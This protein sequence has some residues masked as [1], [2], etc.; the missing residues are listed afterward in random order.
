MEN[1][2]FD[3]SSYQTNVK[4]PEN[5]AKKD[6]SFD[7]TKLKKDIDGDKEMP[8][9]EE[10]VETIEEVTADPVEETKE[11]VDTTEEQNVE[12]E[13][14]TPEEKIEEPTTEVVTPIEE[15]V[16]AK[17]EPEAEVKEEHKK[18]RRKRRTKKEIEAEKSVEKVVAS[19]EPEDDNPPKVVYQEAHENHIKDYNACINTMFN[20]TTEEEWERLK[21]TMLSDLDKIQIVDDINPAT[22]TAMASDINRVFD[23]VSYYYYTYKSAL[24]RLT[25]RET[26]KIAYIKGINTVGANPDDRKR[27][28]WI[29]CASYKE[30]KLNC[31]LLEIANI[32]RDRFNFL[33]CCFDRIKSKQHTL[34]TLTA[35]LKIAK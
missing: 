24:E 2:N 27:N 1:I 34:F 5:T 9:A 17:V 22:L 18:T 14:D 6:F 31:N 16:E 23:S 30:D 3:F 35:A 4:K 7:F 26:G 19:E 25:D 13:D 11:T 10:I 32:T 28:A 20:K 15:P 33:S 8:K 21:E 12:P 29:A